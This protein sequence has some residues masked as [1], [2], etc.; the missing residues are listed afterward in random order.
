[1]HM[2]Q[3]INGAMEPSVKTTGTVAVIETAPGHGFGAFSRFLPE[4][5]WSFAR[6]DL[7]FCATLGAVPVRC[8]ARCIASWC[9]SL[10]ERL[11]AATRGA[12]GPIR[13]GNPRNSRIPGS[14]SV[15]KR[16][17]R[18]RARRP[19]AEPLER[20]RYLPS[21]VL[22]SC[23]TSGARSRPISDQNT[24]RAAPGPRKGPSRDRTAVLRAQG[25]P[26]V[27]R[28]ARRRRAHGGRSYFDW[29]ASIKSRPLHTLPPSSAT[30]A[31]H[32][33]H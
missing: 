10:R 11:S 26:H 13:G 29:L 18:A 22:M 17:C 23:T 33:F 4:V 5:R 14:R 32:I 31:A 19:R 30:N 16:F 28:I 27:P 1:M 6:T 24:A 21:F 12:P 25:I 15:R 3:G 20:L 2:G 7:R 9:A 8:G